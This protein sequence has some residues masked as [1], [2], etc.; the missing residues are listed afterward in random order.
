MFSFSQKYY[1]SVQARYEY[2]HDKVSYIKEINDKTHTYTVTSDIQ[3]AK[4]FRF[5]KATELVKILREKN[6]NLS[7][8]VC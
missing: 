5:N 8:K 1:I 4:S 2:R 3:L 7:F 6:K